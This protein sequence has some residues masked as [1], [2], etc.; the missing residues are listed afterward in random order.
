MRAR[1]IALA[2]GLGAAS[3][4]AAGIVALGESGDAIST[5]YARNSSLSSYTFTLDARMAM[6]SFPWLHFSVVGQGTYE[7]GV[8]YDVHFTRMPFFAHGFHSV[9]LSPLAPSMWKRRYVVSYEGRQD[10]DDLYSLH[11][12][13]DKA[14]EV[15][16]VR[17]DPTQGV[18][19]VTLRYTNGAVLDLHVRC[20]SE[21]TY[22]VPGIALAN[23]DAPGAKLAVNALFTNYDVP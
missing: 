20:I 10:G 7:R 6:R 13:A 4:L 9:D 2:A 19:E 8:R 18:R 17:V 21:G 12:P 15:A 11:D 5:A 14:L 16:N 3:A 1:W 23:V 22:L